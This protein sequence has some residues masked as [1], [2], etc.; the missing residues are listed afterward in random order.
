M[1]APDASPAP[2]DLRVTAFS[3]EDGVGTV[4]LNR[5][6]RGNSWTHRMNEE[7]RW[8]MQRMDADPDVRVILVTGAGRQFCVG[9]DFRALDHHGSS[10]SDYVQAGREAVAAMATPGHGVRPEYEHD[11]VWHWGLSKPVIAGINGACA[12][13]AVALAAFCDLRYAAAGAKIT[14]S[15][16]RLGL[17]A[18]YGLSWVLPR[19]VGL[20]HSA[21]ILFSGRVLRAEE[22]Q[23]MGFL[24]A[25]LPA[26]DFA[27]QV[28]AIAKTMAAN[29]SP[30]AVQASKRQLYA[31]QMSLDP[32]ASVEQAK[33]L[34]GQM[35]R[36]SD[37]REGVAAARDKR[38]P[39]FAP[40][41]T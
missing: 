12:G 3:V 2:M 21:D 6:E 15:T 18:E 17:P 10:S 11:M 38:A 29:I 1:G 14:T 33:A 8:L 31:E 7:Y 22:M 32:G 27:Q 37:F 41:R 5:P 40:L 34:T 23:A 13:I 39:D 26:E 19:I 9:A 20:T 25:V 4:C 16:A 36:Q 35:L 30:L 24:N 28:L